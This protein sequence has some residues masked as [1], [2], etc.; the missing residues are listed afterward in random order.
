ML[1]YVSGGYCFNVSNLEDACKMLDKNYVVNIGISVS[2]TSHYNEQQDLYFN[3]LSKKY[4]SRLL[5]SKNIGFMGRYNY[6][7][8]LI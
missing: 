6:D 1:V 7:Y 5:A 2:S 4:S 8:V 3:A